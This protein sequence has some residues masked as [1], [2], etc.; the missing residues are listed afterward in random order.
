M[1]IDDDTYAEWRRTAQRAARKAGAP[2]TDLD[3]IADEAITRLVALP[4]RP[5]KPKAWIYTAATNLARDAHRRQPKNG[6]GRMPR[7]APDI[8]AGEDPYPE[9]LRRHIGSGN[10]R[11]RALAADLLRA[12]N[13]RERAFLLAQAAGDTL[14][15][16]AYAHDTSEATVKT[17]LARARRKIRDANPNIDPADLDLT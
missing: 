13:D 11:Q 15:E 17:T 7:S 16:I 2:D 10:I 5:E 14:R 9:H 12:V 3:D 8:D 1:E 6:W 4:Q